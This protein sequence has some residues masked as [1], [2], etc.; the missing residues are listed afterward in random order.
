MDSHIKSCLAAA[1]QGTTEDVYPVESL[2]PP[3]TLDKRTDTPSHIIIRDPIDGQG[4]IDNFKDFRKA[5][6]AALAAGSLMKDKRLA[7]ALALEER[8]KYMDT[9]P[10]PTVN[11]VNTK[12]NIIKQG[13]GAFEGLSRDPDARAEGRFAETQRILD[14]D[15][16]I[17]EVGVTLPE[18]YREDVPEAIFKASQY[19]SNM[20]CGPER[21]WP[22]RD[23]KKWGEAGGSEDEG[24]DKMSVGSDDIAALP[25][26]YEADMLDLKKEMELRLLLEEARTM[27]RMGAGP[28]EAREK[29]KEL[30]AEVE[31]F[32]RGR[33][34]PHPYPG[35]ALLSR[36]DLDEIG[37]TVPEEYLTEAEK[38]KVKEYDLEGAEFD[39]VSDGE[40]E[41]LDTSEGAVAKRRWYSIPQSVATPTSSEDSVGNEMGVGGAGH[42]TL[43]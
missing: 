22:S 19:F 37:I 17:D 13:G 25:A 38:K 2:P 39:E 27:R 40:R 34:L 42:G 16:E 18:E 6:A 41:E 8:T 35:G 31:K 33:E 9:L 20:G 24:S 12:I 10:Q 28:E 29:L 7:I 4:P 30:K 23:L 14:N 11:N 26:K 5:T 1:A 3:E 21:A 15:D 43:V 32:V 36:D